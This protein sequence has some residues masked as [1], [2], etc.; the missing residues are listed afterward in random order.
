M[1]VDGCIM[2]PLDCAPAS[3]A[4]QT[5]SD[6]LVNRDSEDR[7]LLAVLAAGASRRLGQPKQLVALGGEPLLRRQCRIALEAQVGPVAVILGCQATECAAT[8]V[9][10]PVVRHI[11]QRWTEGLGASIR[12]A[13]GA[14]VAADATG[15]LLLHVDQCRLTAADLR[16]LHAAWIGSHG[17]SAC[18]AMHGDV[19]GPPVIFPSSCFAELLKLDGD[20]GARRVLSTLPAN[21]LRRVI[22]PNAIHDLDV[23]AQLAALCERDPAGPD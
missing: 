3:A 9:D 16:S 12:R 8:I 19:F 6:H 18:V 22:V 17:A 13:A 10:L 4:S 5:P 2:N 23:P 1:S 11:N 21:A 20:A 7:L 14:A 15:L